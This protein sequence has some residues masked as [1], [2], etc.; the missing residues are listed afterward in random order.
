MFEVGWTVSDN[1]FYVN[2]RGRKPARDGFKPK[3]AGARRIQDSIS[4]RA[5]DLKQ[6]PTWAE[7]TGP[8]A[9]LSLGSGWFDL[10]GE[11]GDGRRQWWGARRQSETLENLSCHIGW[12]NCRQNFHPAAATFASQDVPRE[13]SHH[14]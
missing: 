8:A 4:G 7:H 2:L 3:F 10:G 1:G 11:L 13:N 9:L 6:Y 14:E 12:M 5:A